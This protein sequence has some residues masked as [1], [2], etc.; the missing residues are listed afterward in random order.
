MQVRSVLDIGGLLVSSFIVHVGLG[1]L[2]VIVLR[3]LITKTRL[4][5]FMWNVPLAEFGLL[6][7]FT[8]VYTIML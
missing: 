5:R 2:T 3:P 6:I 7:I 8:G 4:D 1:L